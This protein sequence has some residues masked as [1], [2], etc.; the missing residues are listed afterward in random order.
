[1]RPSIFYLHADII[2][3]GIELL[4]K[5]L[6]GLN[7]HDDISSAHHG[8]NGCFTNVGSHTF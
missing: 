2:T 6:Y 7:A 4:N 8:K 3:K 5:I 1:M